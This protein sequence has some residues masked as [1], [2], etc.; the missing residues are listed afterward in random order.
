LRL[1]LVATAL[2]LSNFAAS[3]GIGLAGVGAQLRLRVAF[4]FGIFET[5]MPIAGLLA[6]HRMAHLTGSAS[7]LVGGSLLILVGVYA[8]VQS[9]RQSHKPAPSYGLMALT[10]TGV[11]LSIDNLVIG[12]ALGTQHAS[13]VPAVLVIGTVSVTLSLGGLEVG[14]RLGRAIERPSQELS[15]VVL[16]AVG[17]VMAAGVF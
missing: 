1:V 5:A 8:I 11:A 13:V 2:G 17:I 4:V 7:G 15:G 16:V 14:E 9:Q 6:G 10:V 12:F 3:I